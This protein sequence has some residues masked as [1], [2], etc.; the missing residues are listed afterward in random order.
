LF[1]DGNSSVHACSFQIGKS[2]KKLIFYQAKLNQTEDDVKLVA[3]R[4]IGGLIDETSN[5]FD[6]SS[7]SSKSSTC[8]A[9]CLI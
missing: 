7:D 8:K 5:E 3:M 6:T 9:F 2:E 1:E 4:S